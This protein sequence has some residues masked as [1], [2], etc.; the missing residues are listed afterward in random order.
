MSAIFT[1]DQLLALIRK[2][3][4]LEDRV[5]EEFLS[6]ERDGVDVSRNAD[7]LA[8]RL[9]QHGLLTRFQTRLLLQGKWK[10]FLLA[11]KYKV[12][13]LLGVGGAG[14]VY[15]CEHCQ[16]KRLVAVKVLPGD[17]NQDP[18]QLAR[19]YREARAVAS[20]NHPN[21]VRVF[22]IDRSEN[23]H[24]MVL[25]HV[26]GRGLDDVVAMGGPMAIERAAHYIAQAAAGLH[27]AHC[28]GWIHRDIKPGNI[29]LERTGV[30]KVLDLGLAR[31]F[32]ERGNLTTGDPPA[33]LGTADYISPEQA[34]SANTVDARTDI[35][36]LGATFYYLICGR[37]PFP[38][39][40]LANKL[41]WVQVLTPDRVTSLRP[42]VPKEMELVVERM[43]A[44]DPA[45]RIQTMAEVIR[46][47]EPWTNK[48]LDPPPADEMPAL[49]GNLGSGLVRE[50]EPQL[51]TSATVIAANRGSTVVEERTDRTDR[52][53]FSAIARLQR[54][55][56]QA[57]QVLR[58]PIASHKS[59]GVRFVVSLLLMSVC[60]VL[61]LVYE[62]SQS[63][64]RL[65]S[66]APLSRL[67]SPMAVVAEPPAPVAVAT[68]YI[69]CPDFSRTTPVLP[70]R[71]PLVVSQT[72][73]PGTY[74]SI[75]LAL[76]NAIA[77]DVVRVE[78]PN[79][80]D[81]ALV[82]P[83]AERLTISALPRD[84]T[85]EGYD[86]SG[87]FRPIEWTAPEGGPDEPLLKIQGAQGLT[88]RGFRLSGRNRVNSL[89]DVQGSCP[90][91][92][93]EDLQLEG[94]R[95]KGLCLN[96][97][98]GGRNEP[99]SLERLRVKGQVFSKAEA[100]IALAPFQASDSRDI[101]VVDCRFEGPF[102]AV[103]RISGPLERLEFVGNRVFKVDSI[104]ACQLK[105]RNGPLEM[106]VRSNT[107]CEVSQA[108]FFLDALTDKYDYR[109]AMDDNLFS[110]TTMFC[111]LSD[112]ASPREER[113][114]DMFSSLS[115]NLMD[116]VSM[117]DRAR[118][119]SLMRRAFSP[120]PID[121]ST[122]ASFL[123]YPWSSPLSTSGTGNHAVGVP[124]LR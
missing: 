74:R 78:L 1:R 100:A 19:F 31:L 21:I 94:F 98:R 8:H 101:R 59:W 2:S 121:P 33:L 73:D 93:L 3:R 102:D 50:N 90:S 111:C 57:H 70:G 47:L 42:D 15:L 65:S 54:V 120:L 35:Y 34:L 36:G 104:F 86:P 41:L 46:A 27:H 40:S 5:L 91:L 110:V 28:A 20:L 89:V 87:A 71:Q 80:P 119:S 60:V 116:E 30:V 109:I 37:A 85:L 115:G 6:R 88:I 18:E 58:T 124:P 53:R 38:K 108:L 14:R 76:K 4:I 66:D 13:S 7:N 106:V 69:P 56:T 122:D 16:L 39:G 17:R 113:V 23:V 97:A 49:W 92:R 32:A 117:H 52:P 105:E 55:T 24:Y 95:A 79:S 81:G 75:G 118:P 99:I 51:S 63:N 107:F 68:N 64:S 77:G 44:K 112:G 61:W 83:F 62:S 45:A 67:Q 9:V 11:D 114:R 48:A 12:L 26:D 96:G 72:G 25:E 29:L 22:D 10:G 103:L 123:R 43:M 84:I 82:G